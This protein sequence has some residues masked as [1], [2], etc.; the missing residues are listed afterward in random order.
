[1]RINKVWELRQEFGVTQKELATACGISR[2]TLSE[3][4]R[5]H[6]PTGDV[7]LKIAAFF[8]LDPRVIFFTRNVLYTAR[9]VKEKKIQKQK[10]RMENDK[11]R[12]QPTS[13]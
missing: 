9:E 4:E 6:I 2:T 3:I 5:G 10:E 11:R 13:G 7:M 1:M 12:S 8:E